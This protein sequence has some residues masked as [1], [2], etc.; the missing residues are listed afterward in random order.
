MI[1]TLLINDSFVL[2]DGFADPHDAVPNFNLVNQASLDK[3]LKAK[4]FVH[5][6]SHLRAAHLILDHAPISKSFLAPKCVIEARDPRLQRISVAAPG[7][8]LS[9]PIP[10]GTFAI[11]PIPKGIS[12][13]VSPPSQATGAATSSRLASTKEEEVVDVLDSEDEFEVFNRAWSLETST[14]DLGPPFNLL[15]DEMGIQRK[16]RSSL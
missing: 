1:C 13:V 16:Q 10:E 9:G 8:L 12:K 14:F 15:I 11:E 3:I 7:F 6:N 4:V 5:T 2:V